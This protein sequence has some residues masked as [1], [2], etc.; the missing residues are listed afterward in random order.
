MDPFIIVR[1][2]RQ[3]RQALEEISVPVPAP[4]I[5]LRELDPNALVSRQV[6]VK[7][8]VGYCEEDKENYC[9]LLEMD[10]RE[11][12]MKKLPT[13]NQFHLINYADY[14]LN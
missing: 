11:D 2:Y 1:N 13:P 5:F 3:Q 10:R 14:D 4:R 7:R 9:S 6:A 12:L 8:S